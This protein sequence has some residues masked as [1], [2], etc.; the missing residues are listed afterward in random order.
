[1]LRLAQPRCATLRNHAGTYGRSK[2]WCLLMRLLYR[3]E[4][5][6]SE[7]LPETVAR[8]LPS[9]TCTSRSFWPWRPRARRSSPCRSKWYNTLIVGSIQRLAG[10]FSVR[11]GEVDVRP[12]RQ[13]L[14][15]LHNGG[16]L[17]IPGGHPQRTGGL[18]E[19]KAGIASGR[20]FGRGD[21]AVAIW[22]VE[23]LRDW[24]HCANTCYSPS[25]APFARNAAAKCPRGLAGHGRTSDAAHRRVFA[26]PISRRHADRLLCRSSGRADRLPRRRIPQADSPTRISVISAALP[27]DAR[28]SLREARRSAARTRVRARNHLPRKGPWIPTISTCKWPRIRPQVDAAGGGGCP[29]R[30]G[31]EGQPRPEHAIVITTTTKSRPRTATIVKVDARRTCSPSRP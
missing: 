8:S 14:D 16:V 28:E 13:S 6:G 29:G 10:G 22:G 24:L 30:F 23:R 31:P 1:M 5:S 12:Q 20:P 2:P 4:I 15:V 21:R 9:I 25:A 17:A 26:G 7:N 11:R 18:Q 3:Y 19:A 27:A